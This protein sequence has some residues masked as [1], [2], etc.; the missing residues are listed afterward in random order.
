M[1]TALIEYFSKFITLT[2]EEISFIER[3]YKERKVDKREFLLK[4]GE[5]CKYSTFIVEGCFKMYCHDSDAKEHIVQFGIENWWI[6][7]IHSFQKETPSRVYIKALEKST[8]LQIKKKDQLELFERFP[9]FNQVFKTLA[10]NAIVSLQYRIIRNISYTAE[11]RYLNFIKMYPDLFN[12]VSNVQ[13]ASYL[14]VTP[15]FLSTVRKNLVGK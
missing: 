8:I 10:E 14:G 15:E 9:R 2:E 13:I 4:A 11:E 5:I 3:V 6:G 7:D 1:S 12:R